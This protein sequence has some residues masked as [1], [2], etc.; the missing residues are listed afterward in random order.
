[1]SK[2]I[3]P[4]VVC[5]T[6]LSVSNRNAYEMTLNDASPNSGFAD[7]RCWDLQNKQVDTVDANVTKDRKRALGKYMS[8]E[9]MHKTAAPDTSLS[10]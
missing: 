2:N 7:V 9:L 4:F 8:R 3:L 5:K 1:M 6:N 10:R